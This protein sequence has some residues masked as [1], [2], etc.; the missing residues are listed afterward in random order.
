MTSVVHTSHTLIGRLDQVYSSICARIFTWAWHAITIFIIYM[1]SVIFWYAQIIF[2]D[3]WKR[4]FQERIGDER[5]WDAPLHEPLARYVHLRVGH[6]PGMPGT[7]SHYSTGWPWQLRVFV[8]SF[9]QERPGSSLFSLNKLV[10][11]VFDWTKACLLSGYNNNKCASLN[12]HFSAFFRVIWDGVNCK[13]NGKFEDRVRLVQVIV[14][15]TIR[16]QTRILRALPAG[17]WINSEGLEV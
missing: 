8:L 12:V 2:V 17:N 4:H 5:F 13:L 15:K 7:F 10:L 9:A 6:A 16:L 11:P 14:N 1:P 3:L